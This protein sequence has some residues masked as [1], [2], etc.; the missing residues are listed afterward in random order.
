MRIALHIF[1]SGVACLILASCSSVRVQKDLACYFAELRDAG[2]I[3]GFPADARGSFR[4]E[5]VRVGETVTYPFS[6][7]VY[8]SRTGDPARYTYSFT[9]DTRDSEWRLTS[10][11]KTLPDGRREDLKFE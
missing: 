5:G 10:A 8:L 2:R 7:R 4:T 11:W 9:K 6:Q 3:P 1:V